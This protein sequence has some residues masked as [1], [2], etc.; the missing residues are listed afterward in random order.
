MALNGR[1]Q[2]SKFVKVPPAFVRPDWKIISILGD[3]MG[4]SVG[5]N[6]LLGVRSRLKNISPKFGQNL[7]FTSDVNDTF[8]NKLNN[9]T[10]L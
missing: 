10:L 3:F 1:L 8:L 6:T 2:H 7:Y 4:F 9:F 5:Y